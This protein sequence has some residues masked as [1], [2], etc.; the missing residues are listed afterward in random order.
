MMTPQKLANE[1]MVKWSP[2]QKMVTSAHP[3]REGHSTNI[4]AYEVFFKIWDNYSLHS[5]LLVE[6]VLLILDT[7]IMQYAC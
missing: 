4:R 3:W 2:F 7:I 5:L 6:L 1:I